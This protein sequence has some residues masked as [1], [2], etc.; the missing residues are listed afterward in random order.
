M[1]IIIIKKSKARRQRRKR[2]ADPIGLKP[3]L[4]PSILGQPV[5]SSG[6]DSWLP[7]GNISFETGK[8]THKRTVEE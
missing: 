2:A 3:I 1:L 6:W 8:V 5:S 7:L 4:L